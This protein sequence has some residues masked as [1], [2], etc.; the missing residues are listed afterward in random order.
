[1]KTQETSRD[2][3]RQLSTGKNHRFEALWVNRVAAQ[4][5]PPATKT[6]SGSL[7]SPDRRHR[8]QAPDAFR[9]ARSGSGKRRHPLLFQ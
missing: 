3:K 1:M 8:I 7:E 6:T 4:R 5:K 2:F 9:A